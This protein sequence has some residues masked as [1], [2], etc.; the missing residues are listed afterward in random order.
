MLTLTGAGGVG[1]TRLALEFAKALPGRY[2]RVDL[3]ELDSL[4]DDA[5]LAQSV[6]TALGVGERAGRSGT[7]ALVRAI[8]NTSRLVILDN[9]EHLAE[10]CAQLAATLL[11]HCPRLR[12]LATSREAL[13]VP[14]ETVF[15]VGE[16]SLP[17]TSAGDDPA[18]LLRSDAVRLF[19]ERAA[20]RAPGFTLWRSNAATVAEICRRLDGLTLGIELAAHRVG[21]LPLGDILA[22]LDNHL[23]Q[24]SLLTDG[25][26]TG[27]RRHNG[28]TAAIDWSHRLLEPTEQAVFRR[29]AVL[30][31]GFDMGAAEAVCAGGGVAPRQILGILCGLEAKSLIVRLP[32]NAHP[33]RFRQL[34][35]VRACAM[36]R[37]IVSGELD[38]V[39]RRSLDWLGSLAELTGGEVFADQA[40]G[41]LTGERDNLAAA[42]ASANG[43]DDPLSDRL[44]LELA[45]VYYQHEQPSAA[46]SLLD[47]LLRLPAGPG[48]GG[49]VAALAAR[50]ACQQTD[51]AAALRLGEQAVRQERT[52]DHPA[53]LA[54]ALD[55]RAAARLCRGEFAAAVA[56][57]RYCLRVVSA[58][59]RR[60]DTAWCTHHLAWALL[61]AGEE[62][63]ADL[64]MARC[65]PVLRAQAHWSR[66]AAA[67][68]TAGA[69]RLSLGRLD[70][71]EA[72]FG[73]VLRIV[74]EASF[75]ALYPVEGLALVA[76]ES[77]D[78]RRALRLYEASAQARRRLDT[79]PEDPWRRRV[80]LTAARARAGLSAAAQ[81]AAVS[82]GRRLRGDRLVAYALRRGSGDPSSASDATAVVVDQFPLTGREFTVAELVAEGLTN[83]QIAA[84][85][86]L[87]ER[88]VATH[89]DKV[90]DKLGLR[91]RTRI[92]LWVAAR[93]GDNS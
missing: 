71:A 41:P 20:S 93:T 73:E 52:R 37:L 8:G 55:A 83:R 15:R 48:L 13:R 60:E 76:A 40:G 26:R 38:A 57:L 47:G 81:D 32:G 79:E 74:P 87:S 39:R 91:S 63:E 67:L 69:V 53:G 89:L 88:T 64:L 84:R 36:E 68:H 22:G 82:G 27:P 49:A 50:V 29:L 5:P 11:S 80:E 65:L 3:I 44:A 90:R 59:G 35:A 23:F 6:A 33:A 45:R 7:D 16:L 18:A 70:N 21:T 78:L 14:G 34:N 77:G 25:S 2:A 75:H 72:L 43:S 51:L 54:N 19:V 86:G 24:L 46:R 9:C 62:A 1:K 12:I 58:L 17:P 4:H 56:D 85:L 28:L 10:P 66:A 31:G 42:L 92:A 30:V 61:Q